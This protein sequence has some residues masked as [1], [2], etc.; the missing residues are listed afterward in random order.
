LAAAIAVAACLLAILFFGRPAGVPAEHS[1]V[2][3]KPVPPRNE[4]AQSSTEESLDLSV[5]LVALT[6]LGDDATQQAHTLLASTIASHQWAYLDHDARIAVEA[7]A[8]RL[9][10]DLSLETLSSGT[11][12]AFYADDPSE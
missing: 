11:D 2:A 7:L 6:D 3:Q 12:G 5:D 8:G 1:L 4:V 9:P 10:L